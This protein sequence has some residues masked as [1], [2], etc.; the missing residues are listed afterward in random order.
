MKH[1]INKK[2]PMKMDKTMTKS[3]PMG[4]MMKGMDKKIK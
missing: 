1:E 3:M 2:M 4:K